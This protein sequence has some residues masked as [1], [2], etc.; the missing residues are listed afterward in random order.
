[1]VKG[2]LIGGFAVVAY[3]ARYRA[4]GI[5]S[6]IVNHDGIVYEKDLGRDTAALAEKMTAFDPDPG[7][8]RP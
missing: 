6:F 7:W 8:K 5:M 1:M 3:P 4:S 2:K